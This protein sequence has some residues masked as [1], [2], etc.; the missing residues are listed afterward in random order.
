MELEDP[1]QVL[2]T[3]LDLAAKRVPEYFG[4]DPM[5]DIQVLTPMHRG[6]IGAG[7]L[8]LAMQNRLNPNR[9]GIE[10]GGRDISNRR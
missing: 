5:N 10:R 6:V 2:D 3:I 7:N 9:Q 1:Q 4:F 8:N